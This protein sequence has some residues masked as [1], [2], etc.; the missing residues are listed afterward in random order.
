MKFHRSIYTL[1]GL[2]LILSSSFVMR[3]QHASRSGFHP[4]LNIPLNLSGNFG[5]F[6]SNHFHTGIDIKTEGREGL[7]VFAVTGGWVSRIRVG[8][9]GFGNALYVDHPNGYTSVYGHLSTF[10][11]SIEAYVK[12]AQYARESWEV[13]LYLDA[14]VLPVDSIEVIGRSGNSG[15]SGGP[16]LHFEIRETQ[17]EF[18]VNPLLWDFPVADSRAPLVKGILVVPL[19]DSSLV[20][21]TQKEQLFETKSSTG[22]I[23]LVRSTPIE[24]SGPFGIGVHT[25]DLLDGNSNTCGV[26]SIEVF[27]DGQ[28][29][30]FQEMDR[31]DFAINRQM[32]AHADFRRF[33]TER[34][35]FH[36]TF[37]LPDNRLPIYKTIKGNGRIELFDD[38]VHELRVVVRDVH[39]NSTTLSFKV[40]QVA[41]KFSKSDQVL[42]AGAKLC[43]YDEVN[44]L[45]TDSCNVFIP[46]GRL[47]DD[48]WVWVEQTSGRQAEASPHFQIGNR[49]EP[50]HDTFV[51]KI[52]PKTVPED[53]QSKLLVVYYDVDK[54]RY[55]PRGGSFHRGWME[56]DVK[57]FGQYAVALDTLAPVVKLRR[58]DRSRIEFTLSDNL[59]GI[60]EIRA[61]VDGKW[62]RMHHDPKRSLIW[63]VAKDDGIIQSTS[64]LFE[65][66]VTDERG[67]VA[68]FSSRF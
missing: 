44:T 63:H 10:N 18:P 50:V 67:N 41:G 60:A 66:T 4:P 23:A 5:E 7:N 64:Q 53:L 16:H 30:F 51:V 6:R 33:K 43:K 54:Q 56:A 68:S 45:R 12:D 49:F 31:L 57:E 61:T 34:K 62:I 29:H 21:G 27:L 28:Q 48:T 17:T 36:R 24:V 20:L 13:D 1:I 8:A 37:V 38:A 52:R 55:S 3:A 9:Y 58:L 26:F 25:L 59:S 2:I 47:Y 65:L 14:G 35:S 39:A 40:K 42:P 19:S 22:T 11:S 46:L 32:N 15:S